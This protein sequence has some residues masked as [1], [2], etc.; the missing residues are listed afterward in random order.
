[1]Q[2]GGHHLGTCSTLVGCIPNSFLPALPPRNDT[3]IWCYDRG[4]LRDTL[5]SQAR[6][7]LTDRARS[8][9]T[10]TTLIGRAGDS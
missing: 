9:F 10:G 7:P 6:C 4:G 1:M 8:C 3:G 2:Q 5:S